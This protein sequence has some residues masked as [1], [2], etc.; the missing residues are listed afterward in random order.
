MLYVV[1]VLVYELAIHISAIPEIQL[2][3]RFSWVGGSKAVATIVFAF[4]SQV[5]ALNL[6]AELRSPTKSRAC[7]LI[8]SS[9]GLAW[10]GYTL[11][12]VCG[13]LLFGNGV[14]SNV[15]LMRSTPMFIVA[16]LLVALSMALSI[17]LLFFPLR[18][19]L[20]RIL[21]LLLPP[22]SCN[23]LAQQWNS[24]SSD[25]KFK[26]ATLILVI[27]MLPISFLFENL[28]Q[29]LGLF[30]SICASSIAFIIP[31]S[32]LLKQRSALHVSRFEYFAAVSVLIVGIVIFIIGTIS[33]L[34]DLLA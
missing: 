31:S 32:C 4:V 10:L 33:S 9:T 3:S 23:I 14:S 15:L 25:R 17:P 2:G 30:G 5:T 27:I 19:C 8:S 28:D 13:F 26:L 21:D 16:K 29:L 34:Y 20:Q 22:R 18:D 12:G 7:L 1:L 11:A 24:K 6:F